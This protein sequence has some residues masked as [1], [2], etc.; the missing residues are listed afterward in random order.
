MSIFRVMNICVLLSFVA[1]CGWA[2]D[3]GQEKKT[4]SGLLVD[5]DWVKS[6]ITVSYS[7]AF[8]GNADELDI[9]VSSDTKI[10]RGTEDISLGDMEQ[11]DPVTVVYYDDGLS[12]L[13]AKRIADLN[14]AQL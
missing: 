9:V 2:Y 7:D 8:S 11:S 1:V 13:K 10:T 5:I 6:M 3:D 14:L 4:I 12:G